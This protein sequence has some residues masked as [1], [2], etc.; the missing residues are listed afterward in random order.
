MFMSC[1]PRLPILERWATGRMLRSDSPGNHSSELA[2]ECA[3]WATEPS[4]NRTVP[5]MSPVSVTGNFITSPVRCSPAIIGVPPYGPSSIDRSSS[6]PPMACASIEACIM[7]R[8]R[9]SN[10]ANR[11]VF[12]LVLASFFL[13]MTRHSAML[14]S[15]EKEIPPPFDVMERTSTSAYERPISRLNPCQDIPAAAETGKT[16]AS[17]P[18]FLSFLS[19]KA[20]KAEAIPA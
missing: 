2:S 4:C 15:A 8:G 12:S 3:V 7:S 18:P 13:A 17:T 16:R 9:R 19:A 6:S 20:T 14:V 1:Q 5:Q 10:E 11:P